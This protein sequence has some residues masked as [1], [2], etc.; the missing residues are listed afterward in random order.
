MKKIVTTLLAILMLA[1]LIACSGNDNPYT[2]NSLPT[3]TVTDSETANSPTAEPTSGPEP[4]EAPDPSVTEP[5]N[6]NAQDSNGYSGGTPTPGTAPSPTNPP[7]VNNPSPTN[8]PPVNNNPTNPPANNN[9][10]T[11]APPTNTPTQPPVTIPPTSPPTT[12]PPPLPAPPTFNAQT[13]VNYALA[14]GRSLGLTHHPSL[15]TTVGTAWNA[16]MPLWTAVGDNIATW[17]QNRRNNIHSMFS[18]IIRDDATHFGVY[19]ERLGPGNYR[20]YITYA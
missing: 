11:Q 12:E 10:P 4:T 17:E 6:S 19:L 20:L 16:P 18:S 2:D 1:A 14:H 15:D 7:T 3:E 5:N 9:P 13:L 8:R